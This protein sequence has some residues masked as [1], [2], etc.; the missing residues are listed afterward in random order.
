MDTDIP[1]LQGDHITPFSLETKLKKQ[2]KRGKYRFFE[3]EEPTI[4]A[5]GPSDLSD[6]YKDLS[7]CY[8]KEESEVG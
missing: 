6:C 3:R 2:V 4:Q 7:Q 5:V 1:V 8:Y